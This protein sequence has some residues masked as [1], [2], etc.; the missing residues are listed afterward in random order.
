MINNIKT[1]LISKLLILLIILLPASR[2]KAQ[3]APEKKDPVLTVS[4]Y[5]LVNNATFVKVEAK[6]KVEKT[7]V[8]I[9][10]LEVKVYLGEAK[11]EN[12]IGR[13][14]TNSKGAAR[15]TV[16]D[17]MKGAFDS[18]S[19]LSI[20]V[21]AT[22]NANFNE[23]EETASIQNVTIEFETQMEDSTRKLR[24]HVYKK[25]GKDKK[26]VPELELNFFA[27]RT[28]GLLPLSA[29]NL[30]TDEEGMAEFEYTGDIPGDSTGT[31]MVAAKLVDADSYGNVVAFQTTTWGKK[32]NINPGFSAKTAL[33]ASRAN[34]PTWLLIVS[35]SIIAAVWGTIVYLVFQLFKI[36]KLGKA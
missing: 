10:N 12:L 26:P 15:I 33:W 4:Y 5:N 11:D 27:A 32:T 35:N 30:T 13:A 22:E 19:E 31:M 3:D 14:S 28:F 8:P 23:A 34:V 29:E 20:L 36:K 7:F 16:P 25:V 1:A 2:I 18:A 17:N 24:A 21:V 9:G 6:H